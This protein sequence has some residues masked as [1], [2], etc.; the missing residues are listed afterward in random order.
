MRIRSVY[1]G[2]F[3]NLCDFHI[4]FSD[5]KR[6]WVTVILGWNGAGKSN[7][8]EAIVIIFRELD[9]NQAPSFAYR[10]EYECS[11]SI[12]EID[13]VDKVDA[14]MPAATKDIHPVISGNKVSFKRFCSDEYVA[15][16]PGHVFGYY[17]GPSNR[18][19]EHFEEHQK[20]FYRSLLDGDEKPLR[21]LFYARPVHANFVLLSFFSKPSGESSK[22]LE[23]LLGIEAFESA[24]FV[25]RQPPWY[26]KS[27][28]REAKA[29]GDS[30]FWFARGVVKNFLA[31]LFE[32]AL[33]PMY[34]P[35]KVDVEF[36]NQKKNVDHLYLFIRNKSDLRKLRKGYGTQAEFFK[37]LESTYLSKLLVEVRVRVRIRGLDGS[38]VFRELSEGE[39]QLLTVLGLLEFTK[40]QQSLFLLDE[41][42]THLNPAWSIRYLGLLEE[43][44]TEKDRSHVM[45]A[46]HDPL[47]ISGLDKEQVRVLRREESQRRIT[48]FEPDESPR[49]MGVV[50]LL[51]SE[52]FGLRSDLDAATLKMID[53]KVKLTTKRENLT[54]KQQRDLEK[55][56]SELDRLGLLNTF[57]DP[58]YMAFL[59]GLSR[60]RSGMKLFRQSKYSKDEIKEQEELVDEILAEAEDSSGQ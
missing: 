22:F 18:L 36:Q 42:D 34:L 41:P 21:R 15:Q 49:G 11:D 55:I 12:V 45:V 39:Q 23:D 5:E 40:E 24:L 50:G 56:D 52:M 26:S 7:L 60:R 33:A 47:F 8:I 9:L 29:K 53:D 3:K 51:T 20:R 46:T 14:T 1:I 38:L 37:V 10:I 57:S 54:P 28:K 13:A 44:L 25:M 31:T 30:R 35:R 58:Y 59:K 16:R 32:T 27:P 2:K 4:R 43:I 19:E 48:S 6:S 17:S